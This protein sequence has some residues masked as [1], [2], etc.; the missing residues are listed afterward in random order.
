MQQ[1][2]QHNLQVL[3]ITFDTLKV[4]MNERNTRKAA[5]YYE[6]F[7]IV[8]VLRILQRR[9]EKESR[10]LASLRGTEPPR[11][12]EVIPYPPTPPEV[13][14]N[15]KSIH[16]SDFFQLVWGLKGM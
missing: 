1:Q 11:P 8:T 10:L 15:P 14:E 2:L 7:E 4:L 9:I 13:R 16:Q 6:A 12:A 5:D 3:K